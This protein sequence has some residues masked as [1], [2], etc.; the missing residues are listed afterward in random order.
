MEATDSD[1]L[2]RVIRAGI[3]E[4][5]FY[6]LFGRRAGLSPHRTE[7]TRVRVPRW[8]ARLKHLRAIAAENDWQVQTDRQMTGVIFTPARSGGRQLT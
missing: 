3:A 5:G 1:R 7:A 6:I 2:V 8:N 4:R